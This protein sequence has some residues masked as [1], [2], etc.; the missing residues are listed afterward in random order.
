MQAA[1]YYVTQH[2]FPAIC[3]DAQHV[4]SSV[5]IWKSGK[6]LPSYALTSV[7]FHVYSKVE[8]TR[9]NWSH[10]VPGM[11]PIIV[12]F[13]MTGFR[14]L[15]SEHL[16][17]STGWVVQGNRGFSHGTTSISKRVFIEERLLALLSRVN[18]LTTLI[19]LNP[20]AFQALHGLRLLPW[21]QHEQ[22]KDRPSK[23]ELQPSDRDGT[24]KYLWEHC[25]EWRY[26]LRGNSNI[27]SA[28]HGISCR[29]LF[30]V[31][32]PLSG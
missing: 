3:K 30:A 25:E 14:P 17:Y 1:V 10:V 23:W 13:G 5:P 4:I 31:P 19:P 22:R 29:W 24:L 18:A 16:E 26:N 15:P 7:A 20:D 11:D 28:A 6:S 27:M 32:H 2:Y 12:V 21:A 9:H 8:V